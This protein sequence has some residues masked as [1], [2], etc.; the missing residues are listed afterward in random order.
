M[1]HRAPA[2]NC[3]VESLH[4]FFP[5]DSNLVCAEARRY[6]GTLRSPSLLPRGCEMMR[7]LRRVASMGKLL[8]TEA[9]LEPIYTIWHDM[10]AYRCILYIVHQE[11]TALIAVPRLVSDG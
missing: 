4:H 9:K 1:R 7:L 3:R 11:L 2:E 5:D 6:F 10:P 8:L